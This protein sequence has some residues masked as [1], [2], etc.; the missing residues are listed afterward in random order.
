MKYSKEQLL[1]IFSES[2]HL[3][4]EYHLPEWDDLPTIPLY[5]DQVV[6]LLSEYL[7]IF[8]AV[9]NDDRFITATM[10]NNYVK[11]KIIPAPVKKKY[12]KMHLAYLII[13]CILKQTLSI[14]IISKI[15]PADMTEEELK[16]VYASFVK[17]HAKAFS[18]VT[19][20]IQSVVKPVLS[21]QDEDRSND[22]VMQVAVSAN[23]F[24][25][26]TGWIADRSEPKEKEE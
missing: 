22:L 6:I 10:V 16:A 19:E 24:K 13:V 25:L 11:M 23:I 12:S 5:M 15:I 2:E 20:Q 1:R 9:S 7:S 17:N 3:L 26:I 4:K 21:A 18:F 14:S 8:A